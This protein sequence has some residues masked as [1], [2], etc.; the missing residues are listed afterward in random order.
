[1]ASRCTN[2][3]IVMVL[4]AVIFVRATAQSGCTSVIMSL[5]PCLNYVTG[6]S[7][8]PTSSCCSQLASVVRSQPRCLCDVLSGGASSLGIT[9]NQTLALALPS[10]CRVQTPPVSE[11][12]AVHVPAMSPQGSLAGS[13]NG[14]PE[15]SETVP[16]SGG[17]GSSSNGN[18]VNALCIMFMATFAS[19]FIS[20]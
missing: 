9:I 20:F 13:P 10:T 7:S 4:V 2:T 3:G 16:G 6:A 19:A 15:G 18:Q 12:K 5:A 8:T 11:C 14:F 17:T 1:M